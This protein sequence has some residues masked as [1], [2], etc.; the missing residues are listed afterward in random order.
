VPV[1]RRVRGVGAILGLLDPLTLHAVPKSAPAVA[2]ATASTEKMNVTRT[3]CTSGEPD[4]ISITTT[5]AIQMPSA[6]TASTSGTPVSPAGDGL[7]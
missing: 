4:D 6:T 7:A 1:V 3:H 2:E 5:N